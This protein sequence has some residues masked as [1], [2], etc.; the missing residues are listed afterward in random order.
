MCVCVTYLFV[1]R[2]L[3]YLLLRAGLLGLPGEV[4]GYQV[5]FYLNQNTKMVNGLD[6]NNKWTHLN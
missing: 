5:S 2:Y 6:T 3:L 4:G 1:A